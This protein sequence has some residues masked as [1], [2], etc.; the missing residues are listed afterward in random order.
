L[1]H[2]TSAALAGAALALAGC[3][4]AA[5]AVRAPPEAEVGAQP[6]QS[7][8]TAS[9]GSITG[10]PWRLVAIRRPGA[11]DEPVGRDP[12]Y[13]V[14]FEEDGRYSGRAHCNRFTGGY[15]RAAPGELMIRAG[16]ATLA[17]CPAPSIGDEFLRALASVA[18]YTIDGSELRLTYNTSGEL[19]FERAEAQAAAAP[20]VGQTFV[21]DCD[22]DVS[23]TVRT[24]ADEMA[25]WA[26]ASLGSLYRVLSRDRAASG[27]QYRDGDTLYWS[28]GEL[29]TFEVG[30]QRFVDCRSNPGKVPWA[31]AKRRGATFRGLGQEPGWF[32]EIFP[33]RLALVTDYGAKRT[34]AKHSGPLLDDAGRTVYRTA[35]GSAVTI[36][37]E[38]QACADSM[39]GEPFEAAVTATV[40]NRTLKGCGRFL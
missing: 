38:R 24:G 30:G 2:F 28:K 12:P 1:V 34:E 33:D 11:A 35:E 32:V 22:G 27:A 14:Q 18:S 13:T 36:G 26:P 20:A 31:D 16:A 7:D 3:Q 8:D 37:I 17:A 29:A 9:A 23:F 25:L 21:Y 6:A 40:D 19:T 4:R 5:D 15:E 10:E 39:S